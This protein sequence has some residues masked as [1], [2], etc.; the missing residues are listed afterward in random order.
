MRFNKLTVILTAICL[1]AGLFLIS[2]ASFAYT[3]PSDHDSVEDA[4]KFRR[5]CEIRSNVG[6]ACMVVNTVPI[7]P[8]G[9]WTG[10]EYSYA[11]QCTLQNIINDINSDEYDCEIDYNEEKVNYIVFQAAGDTSKTEITEPVVFSLAPD[12]TVVLSGQE[13]KWD[14]SIGGLDPATPFYHSQPDDTI[15]GDG[16]VG[17]R[18]HIQCETDWSFRT[19]NLPEVTF[20]KAILTIK[21][22]PAGKAGITV[23]GGTLILKDLLIEG[24]CECDEDDD[25]CEAPAACGSVIKLENGA[26]LIIQNSDFRVGM[27]DDD[28]NDAHYSS[29]IEVADSEG[30]NFADRIEFI[31]GSSS[32]KV[33]TI[34][35]Q[36]QHV[37]RFHSNKLIRQSDFDNVIFKRLGYT[38]NDD[39][40]NSVWDSI[41]KIFATKGIHA[42]GCSKKSDNNEC[43]VSDSAGINF[44]DSSADEEI[45]FLEKVDADEDTEAHVE[46]SSAPI[47]VDDEGGRY[48]TL[49]D[50]YEPG[51]FYVMTNLGQRVNVYEYDSNEVEHVHAPYVSEI[52]GTLLP[53]VDGF[54]DSG[55]GSGDSTDSGSGSDDTS[56]GDYDSAEIDGTDVI[57]GV[58]VGVFDD[59]QICLNNGGT[60]I[61]GGLITGSCEY[62]E[63]EKQASASEIGSSG[64][65]MV[66]GSSSSELIFW[67]FFLVIPLILVAGCRKKF[68]KKNY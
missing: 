61:G 44:I 15:F 52:Y 67:A 39:G 41:G 17:K 25:F 20:S 13:A 53:V 5:G 22:I 11:T 66:S 6:N 28:Y 68:L 1:A 29:M 56:T 46:I 63:V 18:P 9:P 7:K 32:S 34:K 50:N 30:G 26:K 12:Q 36:T 31:E 8:C 65:S 49:P 37:F 64:C 16:V 10:T 4:Q 35:S 27:F 45:F 57:G 59:E 40:L 51:K 54:S 62:P 55:S 14:T 48:F 21:N 23:N 43:V 2:K 60:W 3:L 33:T 24:K 38:L 19:I 42:A 47:N 58:G